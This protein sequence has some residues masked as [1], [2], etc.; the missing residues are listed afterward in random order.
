MDIEKTG[1]HVYLGRDA[2]RDCMDSIKHAD[3]TVKIVSPYLSPKYIRKLLKLHEKGIKIRLITSDH[4][5]EKDEE[6]DHKDLIK[7]ECHVDETR[8]LVR[9]GI[10][11][12]ASIAFI[13]S[14]IMLSS[15]RLTGIIILL[16]SI[17]L[18]TASFFFIRTKYY[19]YFPVIDL[20]VFDSSAD[21]EGKRGYLIHSKIYIIDDSVAYLG[22][23]NFTRNGFVNS[24]ESSIK[25]KEKKAV[26]K[27]SE[28]FD[29]LF[30]NCELLEKDIDT[31]GKELYDEPRN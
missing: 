10:I 16:S 4:I 11:S 22:S 18:G 17:I 15:E 19:S 14:L 5:E 24:Y 6:L 30:D 27:V 28:E 25:L 29:W 2:G 12:L 3:S 20:K 23:M 1:A 13:I 8:H 7:Q 31:W 9:I 26:R 21:N